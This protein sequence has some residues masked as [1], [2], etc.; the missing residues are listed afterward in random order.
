MLQYIYEKLFFN[1][2]ISTYITFLA[3]DMLAMQWRTMLWTSLWPLNNLINALAAI[4]TSL[5]GAVWWY[6]W[7]TA[8]TTE[9]FLLCK[10]GFVF[11]NNNR[12]SGSIVNFGFF[13]LDESE[14]ES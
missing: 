4:I 9:A 12:W 3:I 8:I 13:V 10:R 7:D 5:R 14:S 2:Y 1:N 6:N 11:R